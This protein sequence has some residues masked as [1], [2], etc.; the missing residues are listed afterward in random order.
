VGRC[1]SKTPE[2]G[3]RAAMRDLPG[4]GRRPSILEEDRTWIVDLAWRKPKDLAYAQ[5]L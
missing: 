1:V 2:L 4:R 5:E 3:I